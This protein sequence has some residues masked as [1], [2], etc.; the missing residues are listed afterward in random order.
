MIAAKGATDDELAAIA[1]ALLC[2]PERSEA[3]SRDSHSAWLTAARR[4]AVGLD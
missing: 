1:V 4:E 2:H 3:Q